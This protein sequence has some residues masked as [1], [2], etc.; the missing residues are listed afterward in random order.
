ML[1]RG[2]LLAS[3]RDAVSR[4]VRHGQAP[5]MIDMTS[6]PDALP[7]NPGVIRI[8]FARAR[9]SLFA[10]ED[11]TLVTYQQEVA[12]GGS[13]PQWLA[14]QYS[15]RHVARALESLTSYVASLSTV[16]CSDP[17]RPVRSGEP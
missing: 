16:D 3:P 9:W 10:A 4:F 2:N 11:T 13:I 6:E 8:P 15:L 1:T 12:A 7:H 14:D 5:I 17:V